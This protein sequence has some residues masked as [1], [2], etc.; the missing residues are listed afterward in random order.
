[1]KFKLTNEVFHKTMKQMVDQLLDNFVIFSDYFRN[2]NIILIVLISGNCS[3]T[4]MIN[5]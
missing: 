3:V 1:M 5:A 2:G 4:C